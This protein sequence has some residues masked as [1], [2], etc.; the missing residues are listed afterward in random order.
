[1]ELADKRRFISIDSHS[2]EQSLPV[3]QRVQQ[4]REWPRSR[5]DSF[6]HSDPFTKMVSPQIKRI[7]VTLR[8]RG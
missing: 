5:S 1:M 4:R 3:Q 2:T 6:I 7:F 8:L